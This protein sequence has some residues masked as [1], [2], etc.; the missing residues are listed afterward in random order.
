MYFYAFKNMGLEYHKMK[1]GPLEENP[2]FMFIS[3]LVLID[4]E[5]RPYCLTRLA[6]KS[7]LGSF[8]FSLL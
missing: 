8:C 6:L 2:F 5:T 7:G 4:F 1:N 3:L